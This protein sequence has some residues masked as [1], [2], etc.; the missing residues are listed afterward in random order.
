[1]RCKARVP[2]G[3]LRLHAHMLEATRLASAYVEGMHKAEFLADR[4]TQQPIIRNL[5]T[6]GE[7]A[8]RIVN[9]YSAPTLCGRR[10]RHRCPILKKSFGR[11]IRSRAG[12]YNHMKIQAI[13]TGG[14]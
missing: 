13:I 1:M 14:K 4:R 5:I 7:A 2:G 9:E 11:L 6:I 8:A 3:R 12:D 10:C